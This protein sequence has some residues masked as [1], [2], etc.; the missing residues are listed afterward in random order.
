MLVQVASARAAETT[1]F[2]IVFIFLA[3]S[4]P[5]SS[6]AGE[7]TLVTNA[8]RRNRHLPAGYFRAAAIRDGFPPPQGAVDIAAINSIE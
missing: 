2:G 7:L 4:P 5:D 1:Y 3:N 6:I 8:G